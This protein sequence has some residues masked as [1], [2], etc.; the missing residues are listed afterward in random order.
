MNTI[1]SGGSKR[2]LSVK[3]QFI[4]TYYG[5]KKDQGEIDH[6]CNTI[7]NPCGT[8]TTANRHSLI[9]TKAQFIAK[10]YNGERQNGDVQHHCEPVEVPFPTITTV[11]RNVLIS[12]RAQFISAQY[13]SNGSPEHNNKSIDQPLGALTTEEKFQ[14]ITAYFNS[15]GNPGSQNQCLESP[16]NTILNGTNK[17]ALITAITNG[18]IDFDVKMRFLSEDELAAIMGFPAGYFKRPGLKLSKK[19]I[20]RMIGNA[21][22]TTMAEVLILQ[23]AGSLNIRKTA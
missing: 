3:A 6:R 16:L 22:H 14:F 20:I 17:K 23:V 12:T 19:Q 15:S 9:T 7:D 11:N 5:N 21:V 10:Y 18:M 13:N 1:V 4:A 8:V 2:L